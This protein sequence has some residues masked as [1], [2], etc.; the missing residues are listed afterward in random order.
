MKNELE[1]AKELGFEDI[2]TRK[3]LYEEI[4][5]LRAENKRLKFANKSMNEDREKQAADYINFGV[6]C[7]LIKNENAELKERL[8]KALKEKGE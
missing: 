7:L 5:Q 1:T 2:P 6:S 3:E 4:E 8:E